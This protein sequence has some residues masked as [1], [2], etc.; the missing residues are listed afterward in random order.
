MRS[1]GPSP[2]N[3]EEESGPGAEQHPPPDDHASN[4]LSKITQCA[5]IHYLG[6]TKKGTPKNP[7]R[8][9]L[10]LEPQLFTKLVE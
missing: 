6:P 4:M 9:P 1:E 10:D 5:D 2:E 8:L 7:C 3:F